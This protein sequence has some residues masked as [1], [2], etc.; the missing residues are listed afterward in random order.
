MGGISGRAGCVRAA[1]AKEGSKTE[2]VS[3][4]AADQ[5]SLWKY[6]AKM[7]VTGEDISH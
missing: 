1:R 7:S 3:V 6:E 5:C 2:D 4:S